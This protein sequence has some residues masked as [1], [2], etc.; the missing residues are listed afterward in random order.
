MKKLFFLITILVI[1]I[2]SCGQVTPSNRTNEVQDNI[3]I[4]VYE[5][6]NDTDEV[7][8]SPNMTST[9][10]YWPTG[11]EPEKS[12]WLD[13]GCKGIPG[14][15]F[16]GEYH[17]GVDIFGDGDGEENAFGDPVYAI[18]DGVLYDVS[19]NGWGDDNVG[20]L[21]LHETSD[22]T[23]FIALYGHLVS[24]FER[25]EKAEIKAGQIIGTI[26]KWNGED[27]LHFGI[28][29]VIP[30]KAPYGRLKC[31][32][33]T[34]PDSNGWEDP[35]YW[36]T[37]DAPG[38]SGELNNVISSMEFEKLTLDRSSISSTID[39]F[40]KNITS[41]NSKLLAEFIEYDQVGFANSVH[42]GGQI[43]TS[44]E[45][46]EEVDKRKPPQSSCDY[47]LAYTNDE[48]SLPPLTSSFFVWTSGW[49]LPW[50]MTESCYGFGDCD[51]YDPPIS[52]GDIGFKF[53]YYEQGWGLSDVIFTSPE[54][55]KEVLGYATYECD[56]FPATYST[57]ESQLEEEAE[58]TEIY[59]CSETCSK[60]GSNSINVFP[61]K[62]KRIFLQWSFYNIPLG[63]H[64]DRIWTKD[65]K[66]WARYSCNWDGPSSGTDLITLTEPAGLASGKWTMTISV[67]GIVIAEKTIEIK[68]NWE[69]WDPAGEFYTCYGKR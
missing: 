52:M 8:M 20:I 43:L 29:R 66:E 2:T 18:S 32:E 58:I 45:F 53:F 36:I 13:S 63:A 39:W 6:E 21:I 27:H 35:I 42:E 15:Y 30:P 60:D 69:Y 55:V 17:I 31:K 51:K 9:G 50:E 28:S 64:Y 10:F 49:N 44:E 24:E 41:G 47:I 22:G 1:E 23:P 4:G 14:G 65:G 7:V 61:E 3:S 19:P 40:E 59:T 37:K 25:G 56:N 62:T 26:G 38:I 34:Y 46:I 16:S 5:S 57:A 33:F 67:E 12:N 11:I 54:N 68:G 48:D